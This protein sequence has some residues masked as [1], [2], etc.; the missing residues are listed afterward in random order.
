MIKLYRPCDCP[1]CADI[2]ATLQE[3]VVAHR[4]ITVEEDKLQ[5]DLDPEVALPA[6]N[7]N[8]QIISGLA[9]I[10]AYLKE[11]EKFVADW[12]RFQSDSCYIDDNGQPC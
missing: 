10:S 7:D 9:A 1:A 2:E 4:V 12:Q 11:L 8:G 5:N 3:L 6:I